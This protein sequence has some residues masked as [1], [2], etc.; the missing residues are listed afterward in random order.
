MK[1]D[2]V[3][4]KNNNYYFWH[5]KKKYKWKS[6]HLSLYSLKV[7]TSSDKTATTMTNEWIEW[8]GEN[9]IRTPTIFRGNNTCSSS[10]LNNNQHNYKFNPSQTS[11]STTTTNMGLK[12]PTSSPP[13]QT[14]Q[15]Q[16]QL[17][18][19]LFK[20]LY[21]QQKARGLYFIDVVK[22]CKLTRNWFPNYQ[23]THKKA[24]LSLE[25]F[26]H[27]HMYIFFLRNTILYR[28]LCQN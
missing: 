6:F 19:S 10:F 8:T 22:F 28:S 4:K 23:V 21:Q 20:T 1:R 27:Q 15:Q 17:H 12:S 7:A 3:R 24:N 9:R 11:I 16:Q 5:T 14:Q 18:H 13:Q 25:S 26:I 2:K